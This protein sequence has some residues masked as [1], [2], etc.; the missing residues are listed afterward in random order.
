MVDESKTVEKVQ[1][2]YTPPVHKRNIGALV[3]FSLIILMVLA[4]VLFFGFNTLFPSFNYKGTVVDYYGN[5]AGDVNVNG[6]TGEKT[7]TDKFG[8]FSFQSVFRG[9]GVISFKK[10][11]YVPIHKSVNFGE[12]DVFLDVKLF[13]IEEFQ[14]VDLSED[15]NTTMKGAGLALE[16]N[17]LV[18][19]GTTTPAESANVSLTPFDP[20]DEEQ[21]QAFPGDFEGIGSN[22]EVSQIES[23][24]FAKVQL[25]DDEENPLDLAEGKTAQLTIP[26]SENQR[27]SSPESIPLWN[28]DESLGTWVEKG[29]AVKFCSLEECHYTGTITTIASWWNCDARVQDSGEAKTKGFL[30]K[31]KDFFKNVGKSIGDWIK[32]K[33]GAAGKALAGM[34]AGVSKSYSDTKGAYDSHKAG[35]AARAA[36][37]GGGGGSGGFSGSGGAIDGSSSGS[38]S[39]NGGSSGSTGGSSGSGTSS[40]SGSSS[41]GTGMGGSGGGGSGGSGGGS[42]P[43]IDLTYSDSLNTSDEVAK[44]MGDLQDSLPNVTAEEIAGALQNNSGASEGDITIG[45]VSSTAF[46]EGSI[47]SDSI[48]IKTLGG[49][50]A[51]SLFVRGEDSSSQPFNHVRLADGTKTIVDY[52]IDMHLTADQFLQ[53]N[54]Q[55]DFGLDSTTN[56]FRP[57]PAGTPIYSDLPNGQSIFSQPGALYHTGY[58]Q[59]IFNVA[60]DV[61][62]TPQDLARWNNLSYEEYRTGKVFPIDTTLKVVPPA[63]EIN[64]TG[65]FN[66]NDLYTVGNGQDLSDIVVNTG[67]SPSDLIAWNT[68]S[69]GQYLQGNVIPQGTV[70]NLTPPASL[71]IFNISS[72]NGFSG[73]GYNYDFSSSGAG[74]VYTSVPDIRGDYLNF[75]ASQIA[76]IGGSGSIDRNDL[77]TPVLNNAFLNVSRYQS[78]IIDPLVNGQ[79]I[80]GLPLGNILS[81]P[82]QRD[83]N[84]II[85]EIKTQGLF[86]NLQNQNSLPDANLSKDI[87]ANVNIKTGE[88]KVSLIPDL[89]TYSQFENNRVNFGAYPFTVTNTDNSRFIYEDSKLKY[90][91]DS[92]TRGEYFNYED[93]LLKNIIFTSNGNYFMKYDLKYANGKFASIDVSFAN[94]TINLSNPIQM[95]YDS[96]GRLYKFGDGRYSRIILYDD[97][98]R[99]TMQKFLKG[100]K[101]T[102]SIGYA[103][104]TGK[105]VVTDYFEDVG[106]VMKTTTF[107]YATAN[108]TNTVDEKISYE[109]LLNFDELDFGDNSNEFVNGVEDAVANEFLKSQ[110]ISTNLNTYI[111]LEG[112]DYAATSKRTINLAMRPNETNDAYDIRIG[113]YFEG[114]NLVG[115]PDGNAQIKFGATNFLSQ[116]IPVKLPQKGQKVDVPLSYAGIL[117]PLILSNQNSVANLTIEY[118][119]EGNKPMS[120]KKILSRNRIY[121]YVGLLVLPNTPGKIT[122][123]EKLTSNVIEINVSPMQENDFVILQEITIDGNSEINLNDASMMFNCEDYNGDKKLCC[124]RDFIIQNAYDIKDALRCFDT[125]DYKKNSGGYVFNCVKRID[126]AGLQSYDSII[127]KYNT[128]KDIDYDYSLLTELMK[129]YK[130]KKYCDSIKDSFR[131]NSCY[132]EA[133]KLLN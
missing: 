110:G 22:G 51:G 42:L 33:I 9:K 71:G 77:N 10:K 106:I 96:K 15:I 37:G 115:K 132:K 52:L 128:K 108:T 84:R 93:N 34:L 131:K 20:T 121:D 41:S 26:I 97:L 65:A 100:S 112:V 113:K 78:L 61:G 94:K 87:S 130:N 57:L 28:F 133:A 40:G 48:N 101:I 58:E 92:N 19:K 75:Y 67:V 86:N 103:Y 32:G 17:S 127:A 14:T 102:Y 39:S 66:S 125:L 85:Q 74:S 129:Y 21:I 13:P 107:N 114:L 8:Y 46:D 7:I 54:P 23:F 47:V 73:T 29:S 79:P 59:D 69:L 95:Q 3:L 122:V 105:T 90:V 111:A 118:T 36:G 11:G 123:K 50:M 27:E 124:N 91:I 63:G 81:V 45:P 62:V 53:A 117:V 5:P 16:K 1:P 4:V 82:N 99:V 43:V 44:M 55:I 12:S 70:L 104:Q 60:V 64:S 38:G 88:I 18:L 49:E 76:L 126:P 83:F 24:G 68:A 31:L 56:E 35:D 80:R 98:N 2:V 109:A 116:P 72:Y 119:S 25:K 30:G 6:F 89:L 120:A